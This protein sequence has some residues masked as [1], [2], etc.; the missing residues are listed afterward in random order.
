[1]GVGFPGG[2]EWD[3]GEGEQGGDGECTGE[4][5]NAGTNNKAL[6]GFGGGQGEDRVG[7]LFGP[8]GRSGVHAPEKP[9]GSPA[10]GADDGA[11]LKQSSK[12]SLHP[13]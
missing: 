11:G 8:L 12:Q 9:Q 4:E 6:M 5:S 10:D 3:G 1:M 7:I 2:R 13:G